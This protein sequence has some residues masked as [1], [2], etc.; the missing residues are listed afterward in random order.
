MQ[1]LFKIDKLLLC[2]HNYMLEFRDQKPPQYIETKILSILN[3]IR[4]QTLSKNDKIV[5]KAFHFE[6][7]YFPPTLLGKEND[8][9]SLFVSQLIILLENH[10]INLNRS[11][12]E[13]F[14][15]YMFSED[16][17]DIGDLRNDSEAYNLYRSEMGAFDFNVRITAKGIKKLDDFSKIRS[18]HFITEDVHAPDY[19]LVINED[20]KRP[21]LINNKNNWAL[22]L[23]LAYGGCIP[24]QGKTT[25]NF[26]TYMNSNVK[27]KI[28][29][30][31]NLQP[32]TLVIKRDK[33]VRKNDD[34]VWEVIN[35]KTYKR[36]KNKT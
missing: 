22:L 8:Y 9:D 29:S 26:I 15:L 13:A 17:I 18:L 16:L 30:K 1:F 6:A 24:D 32:T 11:N 36:R 19:K 21:L 3:N 14:L 28:Y 2:K 31:T 35:E 10:N 33:K 12:H 23:K 27:S 34:I 5:L 25:A 20:Y 4:N 7:S